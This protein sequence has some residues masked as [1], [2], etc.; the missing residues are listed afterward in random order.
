MPIFLMFKQQHIW[1]KTTG[2][3]TQLIYTLWQYQGGDL[4]LRIMIK[5]AELRVEKTLNP[6]IFKMANNGE[7]KNEQGGK[8][9]PA[10]KIADSIGQGIGSGSGSALI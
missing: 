10:M 8:L 7:W 4:S 9:I 2:K 5:V 1:S 3:I 6:I